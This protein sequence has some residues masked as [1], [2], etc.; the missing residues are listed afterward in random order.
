MT[1]LICKG[2]CGT[3]AESAN[4]QGV[5]MRK[6]GKLPS[7][8][9]YQTV[10]PLCKNISVYMLL[11]VSVYLCE[12]NSKKKKKKQLF[13]V[14]LYLKDRIQSLSAVNSFTNN[15]EDTCP[16][17]IGI[18]KLIEV[19]SVEQLLVV[20]TPFLRSLSLV[21]CHISCKMWQK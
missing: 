2:V 19:K 12:H 21:Y 5:C 4:C 6:G 1:T 17:C 10:F 15:L 8:I 14:T 7:M 9:N 13:T 20:C 11:L 16:S 18:I 3:E